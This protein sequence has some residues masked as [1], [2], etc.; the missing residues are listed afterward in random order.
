M[1]MTDPIADLLTRIRNANRRGLPT[2]EVPSSRIKQEMVR[3]LQEER[4]IDNYTLIK[5]NK[6]GMLKIQLRYGPN[7]ARMIRNLKRISRPGKRV[8]VNRDQI[9][10]VLGGI[11]VALI[12]TSRGILTNRQARKEGIGGELLCYIW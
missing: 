2:V 5:D 3:L 9:P 12:S 6:Q 4:F 10:R 8:Y 11:G 7:K 1:T